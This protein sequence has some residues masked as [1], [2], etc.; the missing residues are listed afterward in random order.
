MR[1]SISK[2][3]GKGRDYVQE[4]ATGDGWKIWQVTLRPGSFD[5][6]KVRETE[7][8]GD[9]IGGFAEPRL[10]RRGAYFTREFV[11]SNIIRL[12]ELSDSC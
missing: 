11:G 7:L 9:V 2:K 3:A 1:D 12:S 10:S 6:Q 5:D 8:L 4:T